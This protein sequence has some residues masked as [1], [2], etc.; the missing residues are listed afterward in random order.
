[1]VKRELVGRKSESSKEKKIYSTKKKMAGIAGRKEAG[2]GG[3][4]KYTIKHMKLIFLDR[5]REKVVDGKNIL[6]GKIW[7]L[8]RCKK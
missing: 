4:V 7:E 1:M 5:N 2:K 6:K 8:R 3:K